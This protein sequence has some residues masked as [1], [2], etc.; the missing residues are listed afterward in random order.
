LISC[1]IHLLEVHT[2]LKKVYN[3]DMKKADRSHFR[4]F[5]YSSKAVT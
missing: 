5:L 1:N 4:I 3:H 2:V